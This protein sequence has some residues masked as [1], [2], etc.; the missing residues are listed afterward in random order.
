M[1]TVLVIG[2]A[3]YI[4]SHAVKALRSRTMDA[5]VYDNLS[6]GHRSAARFATA[7][8]DAD[9]HDTRRLRDTIR[10]H[11]VDAVMHFAAW[12]SVGDSVRDPIGYYHTN[13]MGTLSVLEA[14]AAEQVKHLVFSSTA[15]VFGNPA[16]TP[17]TETHPRT[18]INAYGETKL[19]VERALPHYE[20]AYGIRSVVLRYFNAAGADPDGELGEDHDP[21][22]H[23]IPRAVDAALGR[24]TFEIFGADY[25]TPDGTCLRDY[26]HVTDLAAA[27]LLALDAL[28]GGGP[29]TQY[30][31]GNGTA[32]SVREVVSAVERVL[33]RPV[34]VT[35]APK[36][37]GDPAVLF[38]SSAR[39]KH[40]LRWTPRFERIET[41]VETAAHWRELHPTGYRS[42]AHS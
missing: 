22:Q 2:G 14:M 18:P 20:T 6:A 37:P 31:L 25:D 16:E 29:S 32:T 4:G 27:H 41:I 40:E 35:I 26:V 3:G 39:I 28:R 12:A 38:A 19:A 5:I 11:D 8:V 36:R 21:E 15:A 17:I 1:G 23:V 13:V 10:R 7:L 9:I 30:N 24:G 42:G 34:P 33:N